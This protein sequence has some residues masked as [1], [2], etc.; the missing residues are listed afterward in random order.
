MVFE[1]RLMCKVADGQ[2]AVVTTCCDNQSALRCHLSTEN[3][4]L[5]RILIMACNQHHHPRKVF[6]LN[7]IKRYGPI[8]SSGSASSSVALIL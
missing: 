6:M 5:C 4:L 7:F 1:N 2:L 3:G 8:F